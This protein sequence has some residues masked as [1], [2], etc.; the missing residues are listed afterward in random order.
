MKNHLKIRIQFYCDQTQIDELF[1]VSNFYQLNSYF[2]TH[3]LSFFIFL[4]RNSIKKNINY[5]FSVKR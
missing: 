2:V 1:K 3:S 5:D 4:L